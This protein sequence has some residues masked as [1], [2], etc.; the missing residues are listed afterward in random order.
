MSSRVSIDG[1]ADAIMEELNNYSD[2]VAEQ[3]K[4][5]VKIVAKKCRNEI[6]ANA[7]RKDGDYAESWA[8]KI[9]FESDKD[10]RMVV[11]NKKEYRLAHLLENGH[12][13]VRGGRKIGEAGA[14]EH[15]RPAELNAEKELLGRVKVAVR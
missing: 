7:P 6:Q 5:D 15:I 13:I 14:I 9:M 8:T 10:I 2:E 11:H 4:K 12:A 1:L 3:I